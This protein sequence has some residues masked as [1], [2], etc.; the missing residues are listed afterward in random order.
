MNRENSWVDDGYLDL[1]EGWNLRHD[2]NEGFISLD[3]HDGF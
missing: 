1:G 3:E 2:E